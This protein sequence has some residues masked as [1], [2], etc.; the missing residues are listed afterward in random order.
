MGVV[1]QRSFAFP[2]TA[3]NSGMARWTELFV[4]TIP[5]H[6]HVVY[7]PGSSMP[8]CRADPSR[9]ERQRYFAFMGFRC[10]PSKSF[11]NPRNTE[12]IG[13]LRAC[14]V[15]GQSFEH[16]ISPIVFQ[17]YPKRIRRNILGVRPLPRIA[18]QSYG[19]SSL[20]E[21]LIKGACAQRQ[22]F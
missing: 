10:S 16:E 19:P 21:I 18:R 5:V 9:T 12:K 20:I 3:L 13:H 8:Y 14:Q 1:S 4:H 2:Q 15:H 22:I 7:K 6:L 11:L 17:C